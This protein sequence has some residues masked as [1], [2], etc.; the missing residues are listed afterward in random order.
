MCRTDSSIELGSGVLHFDSKEIPDPPYISFA[1]DLDKLDRMW[2]DHSPSWDNSSPLILRETSIALIHWPKV[3]HYRQD[4]C[5]AG[6]KQHW[7]TWKVPASPFLVTEYRLLTPTGFWQKYSEGG[8]RLPV[9]KIA[10]LQRKAR[11]AHDENLVAQA[12][13]TFGDRFSD[14]FAYRK[15]GESTP[16]VMTS[17]SSIA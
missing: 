16:R 11:K 13:V 6:I 17:A 4:K 2:D 14:M 12:K 1:K 10:A 8:K 9:T 3:Y 5:W 15:G 7:S